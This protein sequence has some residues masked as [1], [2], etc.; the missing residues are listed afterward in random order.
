MESEANEIRKDIVRKHKGG[1]PKKEIKQ[2]E[3]IG[4]KCSVYEKNL[5]KQ[6]AET[7]G[8][9]LSEFLRETA[10][11]G[12]VVRQIKAL[13]QEVLLFT[14]KLNHLAANINQIAKQGNT[15]N[16]LTLVEKIDLQALSIKIKQLAIDIKN[17]LK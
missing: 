15:Y 4:V 3:F 5:L 16:Q 14:S 9:S 1:R 7:A 11:R 6:K 2:N 13:P 12:Q 17:F 8:L 10:L